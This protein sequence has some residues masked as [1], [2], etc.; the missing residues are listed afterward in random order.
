[1]THARELIV[2]VF[3]PHG[4]CGHD[5]VFCNQRN[6]TG[7]AG[8]PSP[9]EVRVQLSAR[10]GADTSHAVIAFY[11]GS[12]TCLPRQLQ[13]EYLQVAA[14][15]V[16]QGHAR[17]IRL[18]T[19]PDCMDA[20]T[21]AFLYGM[22]VRVV[23]LG[24]QSMDD[25]TLAA[26]ARGHTAKDTE[27]A[28]AAVKAAGLT[29]GLQ[30]MA[31][32]PGDTPEGFMR[33]V[34]RVVELAPSF[35]RIYPVLVV[36]G[37]PLELLYRRCGYAPLTLDEAV[38]LCADATDIFARAGIKVVRTGL[39]PS[40]ELEAAVVAGP[41]HPSFGHLVAS[42]LAYRRMLNAARELPG[43]A[44]GRL[45]FCVNPSELSKYLGIKKANISK[46][47]AALHHDGV[48]IKGDASVARGG[49]AVSHERPGR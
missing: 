46:L 1:M 6:I 14:G 29:L 15:F 24:A 49:L 36:E 41:Y 34:R 7:K 48:E 27:A 37:A 23:E 42:E 9:D 22:G 16:E 33:T 13:R 12:F 35:V 20:E 5:C 3:I 11:G 39:Q 40:A 43:G 30:V 10:L 26:S 25:A 45:L 19:R 44:D 2:P 47:S 28:S 18:S 17:H 4:G 38:L 31:G 8:A 32:L 21:T